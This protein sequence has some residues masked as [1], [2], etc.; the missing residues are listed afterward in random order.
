LTQ[1]PGFFK[2]AGDLE[3]D[4]RSIDQLSSSV[5]SSNGNVFILSG[6]IPVS[7]ETIPVL[8]ENVPD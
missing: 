5:L 8:G 7:N 2:K 1:P 6:K 3:G 4:D